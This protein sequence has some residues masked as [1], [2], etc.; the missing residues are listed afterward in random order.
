M[1]KVILGGSGV[2]RA[3]PYNAMV[4]YAIQYRSIWYAMLLADTRRH[5]VLQSDTLTLRLI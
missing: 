4:L 3:I 1:P 5:Q 2:L